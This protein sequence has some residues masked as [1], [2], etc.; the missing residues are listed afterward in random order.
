MDSTAP[1]GHNCWLDRRLVWWE[2]CIIVNHGQSRKCVED[3]EYC[4][5]GN[6]TKDSLLVAGQVSSAQIS[7]SLFTDYE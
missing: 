2:V 5:P 6:I 3:T 7:T 1:A 4:Y